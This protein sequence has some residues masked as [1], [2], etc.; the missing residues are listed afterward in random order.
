MFKLL[1]AVE[2]NDF[3]ELSTERFTRKIIRALYED[4]A[5]DSRFNN[6]DGEDDYDFFLK[7]FNRRPDPCS[8]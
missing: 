6:F 5:F 4:G 1:H 8:G 3:I 7:M 2:N